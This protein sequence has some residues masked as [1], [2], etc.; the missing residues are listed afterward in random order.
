MKVSEL[1]GA[2]LDYWVAKAE[3]SCGTE[4]VV[5][6]GQWSAKDCGV[7]V[8]FSRTW[9]QGG[10]VIERERIEITPWNDGEGGVMWAATAFEQ[11]A[12]P[13]LSSQRSKW[14]TT[15][16]VAAMRCYVASKFGE[17]VPDEV[18]A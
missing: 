1:S 8:Y 15:P 4:Y 11:R 17:E 6:D 9:V 2:L 3:G 12:L 10:R 16:L 7:R 13:L 14:G 18:P 5:E